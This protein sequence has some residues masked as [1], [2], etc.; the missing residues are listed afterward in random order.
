VVE[1][2]LTERRAVAIDPAIER[3]R[4]AFEQV[5]SGFPSLVYHD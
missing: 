5:T 1:S 4:L 3:S 2:E